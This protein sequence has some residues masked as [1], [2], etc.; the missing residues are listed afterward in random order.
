MT[1]SATNNDLLKEIQAK[2]YTLSDSKAGLLKRVFD[3]PYL[4]GEN[5]D[6]IADTNVTHAL[7]NL[8][9]P[10]LDI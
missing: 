7:D 9:E 4:Q 2:L 3:D 5:P 6:I 8:Q 10:S 1:D